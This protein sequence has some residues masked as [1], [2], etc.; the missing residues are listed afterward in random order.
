MSGFDELWTHYQSNSNSPEIHQ[1]S[2]WVL[3]TVLFI[4]NDRAD[5]A[6]ELADRTRRFDAIVGNVVERWNFGLN[7]VPGGLDLQGFQKL[8][9]ADL[10]GDYIRTSPKSALSNIRRPPRTFAR[11]IRRHA[12]RRRSRPQS[13]PKTNK[14]MVLAPPR[15]LLPDR[16]PATHPLVQGKVWRRS[17]KRGLACSPGESM[18]GACARVYPGVIP[19]D[20][21]FTGIL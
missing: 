3:L 14:P 12:R 5:N 17:Q 6:G 4:V 18:A 9:G 1:K 20:C 13:P 8:I 15:I 19:G 10:V 16:Y 11:A 21:V 2:V 7:Q